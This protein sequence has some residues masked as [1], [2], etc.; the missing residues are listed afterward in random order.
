VWRGAV[1]ANRRY[2]RCTNLHS[3]TIGSALRAAPPFLVHKL[4][5]VIQPPTSILDLLL[6]YQAQLDFESTSA[7]TS[8]SSLYRIPAN[9]ANLPLGPT[10]SRPAPRT[11][12][13]AMEYH[14]FIRN[15][16][17]DT[18]SIPPAT[19]VYG[20]V[21]ASHH[22]DPLT[23]EYPP[24]TLTFFDDSSAPA[25]PTSSASLLPATPTPPTPPAPVLHRPSIC[26]APVFDAEEIRQMFP[27]ELPPRPPR[28]RGFFARMFKHERRTNDIELGR[29]PA[30]HPL[31]R[32]A[33][34]LSRRQ[35]DNLVW[36]SFGWVLI[37]GL[38][39]CI[40]LTEIQKG[41]A[42]FEEDNGQW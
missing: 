14:A 13:H 16:R 38:V 23:R 32:W 20:T 3:P 34:S 12:E 18:P 22:Q 24:T 17:Q 6:S 37:I 9:A 39:L 19:V 4:A 27:T 11:R 36:W 21:Q 10:G 26:E 5:L 40:T 41:D 8:T 7:M 33:N 30:S 29:T 35:K 42:K 31:R 15:L 28:K 1:W 25:S 2:S